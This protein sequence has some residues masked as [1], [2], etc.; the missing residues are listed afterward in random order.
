MNRV[1]KTR[2]H[3][4]PSEYP[5]LTRTVLTYV[6]IGIRPK[7]LHNF[8]FSILNFDF[9]SHLPL[10]SLLADTYV[11]HKALYKCRGLFI[12]IED[13]LQIDPFFAKQTQFQNG[14]NERKYLLYNGIQQSDRPQAGQ[15][16][17]QNKPNTNPNKPNLAEARNERKIS[18]NKAL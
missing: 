16:Q 15:K 3:L 11:P 8:A 7:G 14:R 9:P 17:T 13:S 10:M 2:V 18:I 4:C 1:T 12:T 6:Q 5:G